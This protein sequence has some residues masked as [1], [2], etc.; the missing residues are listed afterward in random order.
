M[1]LT[2]A[3]KNRIKNA[4][5]PAIFFSLF[6]VLGFSA[7]HYKGI[8]HAGLLMGLF[9]AI[10]VACISAISCIYI[11]LDKLKNKQI[12]KP[13]I[14][15]VKIEKSWVYFFLSF[16]VILVLWLPTLLALY[17]GLYCYDASW[18]YDTYMMGEVTEHH[19]VIHTYLIGFLIDTVHKLTGSFNKGILAY[20]LVQMLIMGVG[21]AFVLY[22]L[23][24]RKA[25]TW[26]HIFALLFFVAF[27]PFVIFVFTATKD[28]IFAIAV[29]DFLFLNLFLIED[30]KAFFDKKSNIVHWVILALVVCILRNNAIYAL[31]LTLP[32]FVYMLVKSDCNKKKAFT[33]LLLTVF[34]YVIYKYPISK[35]VT[36]GGTSET[37]ML[38]VPCQQIMRVYKYHYDE[39]P[40]EYTEEVERFFDDKAWY[41]YYV[42]EIADATKGSLRKNLYESDKKEFF[43]LWFNLFKLYPKEYIDSILENTYGFYYP[44]PHYII[45]SF[46]DEGYTPIVVMQPGELNSK[47]SGLLS[48]YKQFENGPI[49]QKM[50]F[51]S[52]L[53]APA[54]FMYIALIMAFYMGGSV[55]RGY[56]VQ[57]IFL[58]LLWL[59]YLLGPVAMVRYALYLYALVPVWPAYLLSKRESINGI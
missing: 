37:E 49:V 36:V 23:H 54:T 51:I 7:K 56:S 39:L 50:P 8:A 10:F 53:F 52:W 33:M 9:M 44:W 5:I 35:A 21:C 24:R 27:P 1:G 2:E 46:G 20:T 57:F 41:G 58:G 26:M 11:C 34:I 45:Y 40:S 28:S 30:K 48:F 18:Q 38:S 42:P 12:G 31:I 29:A 22:L 25:P 16:A 19:P 55:K 32:F 47:L 3:N 17:P 4:I 13:S 6:M 43:S 15:N 59:T 14:L